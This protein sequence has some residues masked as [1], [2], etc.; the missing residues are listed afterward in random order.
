MLIF[1]QDRERII[2]MDSV[3]IIKIFTYNQRYL[4]RCEYREDV[5]IVCYTLGEYSTQVGA[6]M[7]IEELFYTFHQTD[8][9]T[10]KMPSDN[11]NAIAKLFNDMDKLPILMIVN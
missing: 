11:A 5:A 1:T 7:A 2:N 6:K 4:V 3:N 10:F 9:K 8:F